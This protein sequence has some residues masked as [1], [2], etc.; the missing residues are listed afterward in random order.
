MKNY[1]EKTQEIKDLNFLANI[2]KLANLSDESME[3]LQECETIEGC[4]ALRSKIYGLY[5]DLIAY[6]LQDN[7]P[8]KEYAK[9]ILSYVKR[10]WDL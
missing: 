3:L 7:H 2:L 4:N 8:M 1:L 9:N 5:S 10:V 6:K